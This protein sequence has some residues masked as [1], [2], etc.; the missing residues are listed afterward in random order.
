MLRRPELSD[1]PG[2]A[3]VSDAGFA[4]YR[5]FAPAGWEPLDNR[6]ALHVRLRD[7]ETWI[8]VAEHDGRIVGM[9]GVKPG[10]D[11]HDGPVIPGLGHLWH[12]FVD[13][14]WWGTGLATRLLEHAVAAMGERGWSEGRL[15]T[16]AGQARARAFYARE[17]WSERG[18][19][20]HEPPLG[21]DIIELRRPL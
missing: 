6:P 7:P 21:F 17:G 3:A 2:M 10:T 14:A 16:P 4:T 19:P 12:L 1:A 13:A 5:S 15:Y 20:F 11:G 18:A 9:V 8:E